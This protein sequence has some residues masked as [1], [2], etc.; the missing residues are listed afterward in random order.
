MLTFPLSLCCIHEALATKLLNHLVTLGVF[1]THP[2]TG[3]GLLGDV[4]TADGPDSEIQLHRVN[5]GWGW[6]CVCYSMPE[7]DLCVLMTVG[8]ESYSVFAPLEVACWVV[9]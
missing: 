1:L 6:M 2:K 7:C 3:L 4:R 5:E 9:F 8:L